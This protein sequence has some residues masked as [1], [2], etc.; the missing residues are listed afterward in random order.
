MYRKD[1]VL[2]EEVRV[3]RAVEQ[4]TNSMLQSPSWEANSDSASQE[5]PRLLCGTQSFITVHTAVR[6]WPLSWTLLILSTSSHITSLLRVLIL[7][8]HLRLGLP[9]GLFSPMSATYPTH[10]TVLDLI[11][12]IVS[13]EGPLSMTPSSL[14]PS[15]PP[16]PDILSILFS[17]T[18]RL[19]FERVHISNKFLFIGS[20]CYGVAFCNFRVKFISL[21]RN[22]DLNFR[23]LFS[24][25]SEMF[26][27]RCYIING[28]YL[29]CV[30][31]KTCLMDSDKF[32]SLSRVEC[33]LHR[34][35]LSLFVC[36]VASSSFAQQRRW[37]W[38]FNLI[39]RVVRYELFKQ[40]SETFRN[41]QLLTNKIISQKIRVLS[42]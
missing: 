2:C 18:L 20:S 22:M 31:F 41:E 42:F 29:S 33:F 40:H 35:Y 38:T 24:E 39:S 8:F 21:Y 17:N 4:R 34:F 30:W 16:C 19:C 3:N 12:L 14:P 28:T 15:L 10:L 1:E 11:T 5:I 26:A 23:A 36:R 32:S 25:L 9:S 7:F 13:G 6:H 27:S 37:N